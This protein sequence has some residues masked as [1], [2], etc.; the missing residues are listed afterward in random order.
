MPSIVRRNFE[1]KRQRRKSFE[2]PIRRSGDEAAGDHGGLRTK[3][4]VAGGYGGLGAK[5]PVAEVFHSEVSAE[6]NGINGLPL[7]LCSIICVQQ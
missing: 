1:G 3:P 4:P 6:L 5:P 7:T 2:N